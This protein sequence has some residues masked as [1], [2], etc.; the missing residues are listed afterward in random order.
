[1]SC[2][3]LVL[4]FVS[5]ACMCSSLISILVG[6]RGPVSAGACRAQKSDGGLV[7]QRRRDS[8]ARARA[9]CAT[10][11][12]FSWRCS[13]VLPADTAVFRVLH[14]HT[15][16]RELLP[17]LIG[18]LEVAPLLGRVAFFDERLD[19]RRGHAR[20]LLADAQLQK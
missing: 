11:A 2:G 10:E 9:G 13:F 20:L 5:I 18:A 1:M 15:R 3:S 7:S 14:Y 12:S 6:A 16:I 17:N 8:G 19:L 4:T